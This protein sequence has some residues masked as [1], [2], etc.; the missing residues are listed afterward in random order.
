MINHHVN[1]SSRYYQ[2]LICSFY[3]YINTDQVDHKVLIS[4]KTDKLTMSW[5]NLPVYKGFDTF[6]FWPCQQTVNEFIF[7]FPCILHYFAL[8]GQLLWPSIQ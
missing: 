1:Y 5:V 2:N 6:A 8:G 4:S 3:R 7:Q